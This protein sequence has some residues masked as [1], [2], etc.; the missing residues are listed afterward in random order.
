MGYSHVL[1]DDLPSAMPQRL[2]EARNSPIHGRGVFALVARTAGQ[3]VA[4]YTGDI[5]TDRQ[6]EKL[7]AEAQEAGEQNH[8]FLFAI[9]G[10]RNIDATRRNVV[11]KWINHSCEPNC[12]ATEDNGRVFIHALRDIRVGE[13][14]TY[15]YNIVLEVRHT[16]KQK[17]RFR[18]LC[19]SVNC[20]GTLLADK[21]KRQRV[22]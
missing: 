8:T 4:E 10:G 22:A 15:D 6:A 21:R 14:I 13:E 12:E 5:I 19:G 11:A 20:R 7:Y 1:P 18:C 3:R 2:I 16:A 9:D 17:A